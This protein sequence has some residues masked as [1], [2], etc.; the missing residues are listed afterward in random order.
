LAEPPQKM[1]SRE[2][3]ADAWVPWFFFHELTKA[4]S[5][6]YQTGFLEITMNCCK[7]SCFNG[8]R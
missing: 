7:R 6:S 1:P 2:E 3:C 4:A 5:V 8:N